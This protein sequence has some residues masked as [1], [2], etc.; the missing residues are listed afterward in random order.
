LTVDYVDVLQDKARMA[1][2]LKHSGSERRVPV[3]VE[4]GKVIIGFDG[5]S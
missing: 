5:G 4:R 2:M 3:I 1:E